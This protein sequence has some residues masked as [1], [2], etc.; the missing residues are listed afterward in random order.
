MSQQLRHLLGIRELSESVIADIFAQAK[1]FKGVLARPIKKVPA[2]RDTTIANVFFEPSTRTKVSFELAAK[3]L[4][5]DVVNFVA[6]SS[7]LQKGE[8]LVDTIQN[9][10][11]MRVDVV[12]IRHS[13]PGVPHFLAKEVDAQ[14]INAGDGTHEHPT[15]A[16]LDT[17]S[18]I[19][20]LG[21]LKGCRVLLLGD[22][23]HSRVARSNILCLQKLG[24]EVTLCGPATLI[25]PYV[26][27]LG[28]SL[29][30][31]LSEALR[32]CDV[33]NVLRLQTERQEQIFL[34]SIREYVLHYRLNRSDLLALKNRPIVM[35]PGPMNR[36]IEIESSV[37]DDPTSIILEQV[38]NGVAIRMA[39][40]YML[41]SGRANM[42]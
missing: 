40:L 9:I 32:A 38:E 14:V 27:E 7:A 28:V 18:M 13:Q 21:P 30:Y 17:F 42:L 3:R 24:A 5:A 19:E 37:A 6:S 39:V 22:V 1:E 41:S 20:R 10:L 26:E 2:L 31:D 4:S 29:S 16:L 11:H 25:P 12:V 34:P 35:H 8:S 36:G 15:Q 23:L 33:V